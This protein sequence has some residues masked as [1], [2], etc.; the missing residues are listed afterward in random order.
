MTNYT[1]ARLLRNSS[2]ADWNLSKTFHCHAALDVSGEFVIYSLIF[3]VKLIQQGVNGRLL[4][5][6][7]LGIRRSRITAGSVWKTDNS[8][9]NAGKYI[10][11]YHKKR[12]M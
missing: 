11:V 2:F 1:L 3:Y 6:T 8:A 7:P 5:G 12:I 9:T 10:L 4:F